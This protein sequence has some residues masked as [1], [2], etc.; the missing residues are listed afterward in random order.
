MA[1]G[2][3]FH[4]RQRQSSRL[5]L[6]KIFIF[7]SLILHGRTMVD[8]GSLI[9]EKQLDELAVRHGM[10]NANR[11]RDL[12]Q[13]R[14]VKDFTGTTLFD[15][16]ARTVCLANAVPRKELFE[17]WATASYVQEHF[18]NSRRIADLASSH[19]LLSWALLVM[20]SSPSSAG[21]SEQH[22]LQE[23]SHLI[24]RTAVCIDAT[25]PGSAEKVQSAMTT[26]WP[27]LA[28]CWDYVEGKL[29]GTI[30]SPSTLLVGVHCCGTLSDKVIDLAIQGQCSL[31]LVPCCHSKQSLLDEQ[32]PN[33]ET[34]LRANN[35]TL[36]DLID[37]Q[38]KV[39]LYNAGFNVQ[40]KR[41]P[42]AFTPKNRIILAA[43][44]EF[45]TVVNRQC[46]ESEAPMTTVGTPEKG[47]AASAFSIP[48]ADSPTAMSVIKSLAGREAANQRKIPPPPS[49]CLSLFL[50]RTRFMS[51][52]Q[53]SN[54]ANRD[55][56]PELMVQARVEAVDEKPV[57]HKSG[58]NVRTFRIFYEPYSG[59]S[60][61]TESC[62]NDNDGGDGG[63]KTIVSKDMAKQLF[64]E[65]CRR[66]P[67]EF[68][69]S[70][71]RN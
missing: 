70:S 45:N 21:D 65:L 64:S 67:R 52:R 29:E 7:Y 69:G 19:G 6:V 39:R 60:V 43:P 37:N 15:E 68:P 41:I 40:E 38:R 51:L 28:T 2:V 56:D 14:H 55:L 17:A 33:L 47:T 42:A 35:W 3:S 13:P 5:V 61:N 12:L 44:P 59:M 63:G 10:V 25:M 4:H 32:L 16:F 36:A 11:P 54:L 50:P 49:L 8:S 27:H 30:P 26:Q 31:A 24:R 66:I 46:T 1:G 20:A 62:N 22:P 57:L 23:S 58:K 34:T 71:V 53:L 48:V 18:P 9:L